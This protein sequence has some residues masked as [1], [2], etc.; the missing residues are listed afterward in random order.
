MRGVPAKQLIVV[1]VGHNIRDTIIAAKM[2][3][4]TVFRREEYVQSMVP[5][6]RPA[7]MKDVLTM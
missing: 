7:V 6:D 4:L 1:R 2:G 3:A 5:N